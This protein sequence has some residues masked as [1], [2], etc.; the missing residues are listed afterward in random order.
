MTET[1]CDAVHVKT[2]YETLDV[3]G[4]TRRQ[5]NARFGL[6]SPDFELEEDEF[7]L[8]QWFEDLQESSGTRIIQGEPQPLSHTDIMNWAH[9]TSEIIRPFEVGILIKMSLAWCD[10]IIGELE[11][12]RAIAK[13]SQESK[14][15]R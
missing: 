3:N 2:K 11:N 10:A 1:L 13:E 9:N 15:K 8:W 4:E 7:Y 14:G 6:E 5:R 12:N